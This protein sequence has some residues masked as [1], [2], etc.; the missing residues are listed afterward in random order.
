MKTIILKTGFVIELDN[1][2]MGWGIGAKKQVRRFVCEDGEA[3]DGGWIAHHIEEAKVWKT[4]S[5]A[6]R[7]LAARSGI[8]GNVVRVM[9][10]DNGN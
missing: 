6:R 10:D 2:A 7:W 8:K 9:G 1:A 3:W 4:A 5:G